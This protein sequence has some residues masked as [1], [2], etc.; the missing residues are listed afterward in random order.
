MKRHL[1]LGAGLA[2]ALVL[3]LAACAGSDEGSDPTTTGATGPRAGASGDDATTRTPEE[4]RSELATGTPSTTVFTVADFAA[5]GT[6]L[7]SPEQTQGP[8]PTITQIERR[9]LR[10][11]LEG[12]PLRLG[13]QV[14]DETCT[15]VPGAAG[16]ITTR[17]A[18]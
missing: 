11:G 6:C 1:W 15:P 4:G 18:P 8:Y 16:I 14:V 3:S 9:D 17:D 10:E 2:C 5:L 7:L 13:L 12:H